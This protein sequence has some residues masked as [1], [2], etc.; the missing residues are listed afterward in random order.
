MR[1]KGNH[2]ADGQADEHTPYAFSRFCGLYQAA[3]SLSSPPNKAGGLFYFVLCFLEGKEQE[4]TTFNI[5]KGLIFLCLSP[6]LR[7]R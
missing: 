3:V 1:T 7:G 5:R 6:W 2:W 4:I